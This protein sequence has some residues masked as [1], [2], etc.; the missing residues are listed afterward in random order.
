MS[1]E[2]AERTNTTPEQRPKMEGGI[3]GKGFKKGDPRINRKGRPKSFDQLRAL[4]QKISHEPIADASSITVAEAILRTMAKE[5]P[6]RFVE[7]A[8]G[9][10]PDKLEITTH[11][12]DREIERELA[13]VAA[14]SKAADA[15]DA[16]N[17][18]GGD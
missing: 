1:D 17:E 8:F 14:R 12:I 9:K 15:N 13:R 3:T 2:A 16:E 11:D 5:N 7:I 6:A 10:V 18:G 4:A